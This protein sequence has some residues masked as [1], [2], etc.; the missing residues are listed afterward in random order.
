MMVAAAL[1][2]KDPREHSPLFSELAGLPPLLIQVG[3]S[4]AIFDD[5]RRYAEAA[6]AAG[7]EVVFEPWEDMIHLWHGF[8]YLPQA[9]RATERIAEFLGQHLA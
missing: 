2:G 1:Q 6:S 4:E 5:G 7:V 8:P 9:I 3:T